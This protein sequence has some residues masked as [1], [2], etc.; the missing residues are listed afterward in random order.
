MSFA[1]LS[2]EDIESMWSK[3][4]IVDPALQ[5]EESLKKKNLPSKQGL[6]AFLK[7]CCTRRH[8][9]FQIKKCGSSTCDIC[10]PV[11][12]P[13]EVFDTLHVLP[14]PV[15]GEDGHYK[16]L[17]NSLGTVT[18]TGHPFK[19]RPNERKRSLFQPASRM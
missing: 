8:Y 1:P 13:K 4:L 2:E 14:N 12:L 7:H 3:L 17:D 19:R 16:S 10:K 11:R 5:K 18:D 9:S 6:M 15:P